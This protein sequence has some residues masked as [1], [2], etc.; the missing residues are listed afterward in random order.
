MFKSRAL[1]LVCLAGAAL[2]MGCQG[3]GAYF[4]LSDADCGAGVCS[5]QHQCTAVQD[6]APSRQQQQ[7]QDI[8]RTDNDDNTVT[9]SDGRTVWTLDLENGYLRGSLGEVRNYANDASTMVGEYDGTYTT[10]TLLSETGDEA[11]MTIVRVRGELGAMQLERGVPTEIPA[12]MGTVV[13]CSG[14]PSDG[15]DFDEPADE[16]TVVMDEPEDGRRNY[17]VTG[18]F[19]DDMFVTTFDEI[20]IQ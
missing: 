10:I 14:D 9:R 8:D 2:A 12:N 7:Q 16:V 19:G 20:D 6:E 5:P 18:R 1:A 4:C 15:W 13:G 3:G 11:V 17:T